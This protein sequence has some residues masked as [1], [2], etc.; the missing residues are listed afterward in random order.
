MHPHVGSC[1]ALEAGA[2]NS[3]Q[4]AAYPCDLETL[5]KLVEQSKSGVGGA[6]APKR[7]TQHELASLIFARLFWQRKNCQSFAAEG[8][9]QVSRHGFVRVSV[10][11]C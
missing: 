2:G 5:F 9:A 7:T 1:G 8:N 3:D 10:K 6:C 11:K 4:W